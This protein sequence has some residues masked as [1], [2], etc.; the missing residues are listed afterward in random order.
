MSFAS[1]S[2][3]QDAAPVLLRG[4][5]SIAE[6]ISKKWGGVSISIGS[7]VRWSKD[8]KDPLPIKKIKAVGNRSIIVADSAAIDRWAIRRIQ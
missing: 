5:K 4:Y 2:D 8:V 3:V 6:R 1:K 7:V